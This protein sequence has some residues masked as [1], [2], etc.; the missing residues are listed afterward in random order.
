MKK[1]KGFSPGK[2]KTIPVM[3]Q[4]FTDVLPL[5]DDLAELKV[6]LF[7][8]RALH[9]KEGVYRFLRRRDFRNDAALMNGLTLIDADSDAVLDRGLLKSVERGTLLCAEVLLDKGPETLYF[10]NTARGRT[11]VDQIRAGKWRPARDSLG[12][13]ILPERPNIYRLYEANV[14]LL[15]PLIADALKEAENDYPALWIEDAIKLSVEQN[16][17]SWSYI[18]AILERWRREGRTTYETPQRYHDEDG[19]RYVRGK[20]SDF[21]ES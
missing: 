15:T 10:L 11:A 1:F 20:F 19:Q 8:L 21:I 14:G 13:E 12:I 17:R 9:Q 4:F 18:R 16:K 5:I 3:V 2:P 7:C 6:L